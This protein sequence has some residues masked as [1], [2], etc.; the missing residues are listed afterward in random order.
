MGE[1]VVDMKSTCV[2]SLIDYRLEQTMSNRDD[3][4]INVLALISHTFVLDYMREFEMLF[5]F[6]Q[7]VSKRRKSL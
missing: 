1:N 2:C 3:N 4:D 5:N 6:V 7:S